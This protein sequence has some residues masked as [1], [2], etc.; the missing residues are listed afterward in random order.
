MI[1]TNFENATQTVK[2]PSVARSAQRL[3]NITESSANQPRATSH[4]YKYHLLDTAQKYLKDFRVSSCQRVPVGY[5]PNNDYSSFE[6]N[7]GSGDDGLTKFGGLSYCGNLWQCPCCAGN[8]AKTKAAEVE[9]AMR[10]NA[11]RGGQC[12]FVTLTQPHKSKDALKPLV[13]RQ[14]KSVS[15]VMSNGTVARF[16]KK[17]G[18]VGQVRA[19]EVTHG[20]NGWHPHLHI[21]MFF[22]TISIIKE[23]QNLNDVIYKAWSTQ[24][25]K[26]GGMKPTLEHGVDVRLPRNGDTEEIAAYVA[27]WGMEVTNSHTK[28]GRAKTSRTPFQILDDLADTYTKRDH[29]LLLEYAE[30]TH[31]KTRIYWSPDLKKRFDVQEFTDEQLANAPVKKVVFTL[32]WLDFCVIRQLNL[33]GDLLDLAAKYSHEFLRNYVKNVTDT[34]REYEKLQSIERFKQRRLAVEQINKTVQAELDQMRELGLY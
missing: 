6:V 26:N 17:H 3:G 12:V 25:V 21:I 15:S 7:I 13:Q 23:K 20:Q 16:L 14:Q 29:D 1:N 9:H 33:C 34:F 31:K 18:Y 28:K 5:S 4:R 8:V 27:K 11:K 2:N 30:G 24:I 10:E 32:K 19:F 22:D